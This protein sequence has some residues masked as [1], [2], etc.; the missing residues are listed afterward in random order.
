[1]TDSDISVKQISGDDA[2]RDVMQPALGV[3]M[4][5]LLAS[6]NMKD[7]WKKV[8]ANKGASGIDGITV[9]EYPAWI[10]E[11]WP[12]IQREL[13]EGSYKPSPVLRCTIPKP[14]GGKRL[15]GIPR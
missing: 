4:Y 10:N 15:L 14:D 5:H 11:H 3:S 9:Q 8:K 2:W 1:M 7:A 6:N 13:Q 12:R